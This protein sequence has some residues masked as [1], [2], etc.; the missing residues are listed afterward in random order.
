MVEG[1]VLDHSRNHGVP[2]GVASEWRLVGKERRRVVAVV[3]I[4]HELP[5][6]SECRT[7]GSSVCEVVLDCLGQSY[8]V[9]DFRLPVA[10]GSV[11]RDTK[12]LAVVERRLATLGPRAHVVGVHLFQGVDAGVVGVGADGA[13]WAVGCTLGL[14]VARLTHVGILLGLVVKE[15]HGEQLRLG[16]TAEKVLVDTFGVGDDGVAVEGFEVCVDGGRVI[17][18]EVVFLIESPHSSPRISSR[19]GP[20][21]TAPTQ[22]MTAVKYV[23]DENLGNS[24]ESIVETP[25]PVR[26]VVVH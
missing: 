23:R 5:H 21:N 9:H 13:Q 7:L 24:P 19:G 15:P 6:E 10:L 20:V 26:A 3:E 14:S 16:L 1:V 12:H 17:G 25:H 18:G 4:H 22:S 8:H 11:V 2:T